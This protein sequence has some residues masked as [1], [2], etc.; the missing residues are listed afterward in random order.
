[1]A[2][3][4][5]KKTN[6]CCNHTQNMLHYGGICL[7]EKMKHKNPGRVIQ[8]LV[9]CRNQTIVLIKLMGLVKL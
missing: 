8:A 7:R 9:Q 3:V 5:Q 2:L 6:T 4:Q 1:M